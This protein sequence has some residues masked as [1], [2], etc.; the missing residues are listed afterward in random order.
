M[1]VCVRKRSQKFEHN[2][3]QRFAQKH[4][5]WS[6]TILYINIMQL[7]V[8]AVI[9]SE[10]LK[11]DIYTHYCFS[12]LSITQCFTYIRSQSTAMEACI[13]ILAYGGVAWHHNQVPAVSANVLSLHVSLP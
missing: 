5:E 8:A 9:T 1:C 3:V 2:T 7:A 4:K 13:D 6:T 10:V 11:S 12:P